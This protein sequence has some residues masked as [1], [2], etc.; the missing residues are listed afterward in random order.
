[1][2]E[3]IHHSDI[4][5]RKEGLEKR[6]GVGMSCKILRD[7]MAQPGRLSCTDA[8][9]F[10]ADADCVAWALRC[11]GCWLLPNQLQKPGVGN[12]LHPFLTHVGGFEH[13][14]FRAADGAVVSA[15]GSL[16]LP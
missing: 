13:Q 15:F 11:L 14:G 3:D 8:R 7:R 5:A 12:A 6:G 2:D 10:S 16:N 1:M 4:Y 9:R